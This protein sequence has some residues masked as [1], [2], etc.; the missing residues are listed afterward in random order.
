MES[1]SNRPSAE[2]IADLVVKRL[3][4]G[5]GIPDLAGGIGS[6]TNQRT[7]P[8]N[9][10]VLARRFAGAVASAQSGRSERNA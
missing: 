1:A 10:E 6:K 7:D 9:R 5:G 8:R 4:E 2:E 3:V